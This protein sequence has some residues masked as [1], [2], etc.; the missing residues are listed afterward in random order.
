M[1]NSLT[2]SSE[3]QWKYSCLLKIIRVI[4]EVQKKEH[5]V[6]VRDAFSNGGA[7]FGRFGLLTK[8]ASLSAVCTHTRE[9][10]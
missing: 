3:K 8:K 2:N 9:A 10:G 6:L 7:R 5:P 1:L 4:S